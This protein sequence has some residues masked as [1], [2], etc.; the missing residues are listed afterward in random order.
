MIGQHARRVSRQGSA[1]QLQPST[2]LQPCRATS[3]QNTRNPAYRTFLQRPDFDHTFRLRWCAHC[4]ARTWWTP[5]PATLVGGLSG[6][7]RS[8]LPRDP[9]GIESHDNFDR[10]VARHWDSTRLRGL[11]KQQA[12]SCGDMLLDSGPGCSSICAGERLATD[13]WRHSL[14]RLYRLPPITHFLANCR[15]LGIA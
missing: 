10:L 8:F 14:V 6:S 9:L 12:L 3:S 11:V 15:H 13:V 2:Q 4:H 1:W 5:P 7:A